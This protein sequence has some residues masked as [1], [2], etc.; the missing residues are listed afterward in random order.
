MEIQENLTVASVVAENIKTAHVFKKHGIDFCCGGGIS[1]QKACAKYSVDYQTLHDELEKVDAVKSTENNFNDWELDVLIDHIIDVHHSY[2][3]ESLPL[4]SQ[5]A[6]KVASVHGDN[7][8]PL[9][10][11]NVLVHEIIEELAMHLKKEE[12]VLFPYIKQVLAAK[13]AGQEVATPHFQTVSNPISM[14][15]HEHETVGDVFKHIAGL[16]N[17]YTPPEWACN[18]FKALYA[19]LEEFEQDLHQHIHLENNILHPKAL[20][21]EKM[22]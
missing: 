12:Q 9:L 11:I 10:E 13:K 19:K 2:V 3:L 8:K 17:N 21:L 4:L 20:A 16:T 14:M 22:S 15:E 1:I 6:Q 7:H 5:Y 18:T